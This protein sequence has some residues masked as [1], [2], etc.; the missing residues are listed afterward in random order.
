M[1][2]FVCVLSG[3]MGLDPHARLVVID[4]ASAN[5]G[6]PFIAHRA[7]FPFTFLRSSHA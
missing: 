2:S 6:F 4:V 3:A 7:D 5:A 1:G